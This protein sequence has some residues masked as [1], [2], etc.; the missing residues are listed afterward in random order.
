MVSRA[1]VNKFEHLFS[2]QPYGTHS[3]VKSLA[4][5]SSF[6]YATWIYFLKLDLSARHCTV[7][8]STVLV[9]PMRTRLSSEIPDETWE[10]TIS[11]AM[12]FSASADTQAQAADS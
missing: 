2:T 8:D 1:N 12:Q 10:A 6:I 7:Y 11:F 3:D 4:Y 5:G 9:I